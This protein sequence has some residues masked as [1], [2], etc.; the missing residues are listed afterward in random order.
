[1]IFP[2]WPNPS[3]YRDIDLGLSRVFDLLARLDNPHLKLP[4]T[5]HLAGTNGKGSTLS[6][7]RTIFTESRLKVHTYTSPH[8]VNFNERIVLNG[9]EISDDYLNEILNECKKAAEIS[10]E[11]K[12]TFFEGITVAAFLIFSRVKADVLLLETGMGGRLDATNVLPKVLCSIITP[13]AFDHQEF[14]G[15][16]LAKIAFEKGGIIKKN[17]PT[18]IGKQ[19]TTALRTL[20]N[21]AL[22][23]NSEI[24]TFTKDFK[25]K[26][27]KSGFLFLGF[28]KKISLPSPSLLGN[29]QIENAA[30]A[31]AAALTRNQFPIT[32]D[33]IKSALQKTI[34]PARLQKITAGKFYEILPKNYELYLDGS[35]NLQG[36]ATI[37]KFLRENKNK[38]ICV[39][40]SM[41][42]DKDAEGFLKKITNDID[43]L[44]TLEIPDE[45]KSRKALELQE[46]AKRIGIN[47]T[48][49]EN[50]YDAI[51]SLTNFDS[52]KRNHVD[53]V[54]KPRPAKTLILIC[55][56]LYLAGDFLKKNFIS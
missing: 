40:F 29:H 20:E 33:N 35:H 37:Q 28:G 36:A 26:K 55:G 22:K 11:I 47:T 25:I 45:P 31:I 12:V 53:G 15:K 10:P 19:K 16:T 1:M 46:I 49:A 51:T 48:T 54:R 13:I 38:K 27:T 8:L 41:L 4:P 44:I 14:L 39:I 18:I 34:W 43:E 9:T 56:S 5:I 6:F 50:F 21:Q 24:K 52:T 17:C 7:L 42:K 2:F 23:A 30:T 3:G 32:E